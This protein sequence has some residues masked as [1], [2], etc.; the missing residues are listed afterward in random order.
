MH[1]K[2]SSWEAFAAYPAGMQHTCKNLSPLVPEQI[3]PP[4]LPTLKLS[5]YLSIVLGVTLSVVFCLV[6]GLCRRYA[7][8]HSPQ[9]VSHPCP[10]SMDPDK[11]F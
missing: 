10:A 9:P 11:D 1:C 3:A 4:G 5:P 8:L 7:Q 2:H 6:A